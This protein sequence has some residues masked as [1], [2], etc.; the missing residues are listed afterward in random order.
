MRIQHRPSVSQI[1]PRNAQGLRHI[2][3][4]TSEKT[5]PDQ[6]DLAMVQPVVDMNMQ[7]Y[8]RLPDS[9][10]MLEGYISTEANDVAS[11][12]PRL[13]SYVSA[14]VPGSGE[15]VY[16]A[17]HNLLVFALDWFLWITNAD[18]ATTS[19]LW[20]WVS[21]EMYVPGHLNPV[22]I[23]RVKF[24]R[25]TNA[26]D[27]YYMS[28][29]SE[30][31]QGGPGTRSTPAFILPAGC[32]LEVRLQTGDVNFSPEPAHVHLTY[33]GLSVQVKGLQVPQGAPIPQL[34]FN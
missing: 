19:A 22:S 9:R 6:I 7:G 17:N 11:I 23:W 21:L 4:I 2:F 16:D 29:E 13:I 34:A 3:N 28:T 1:D 14:A 31:T 12:H 5:N 24:P 8:A 18:H 30:V 33:L 32:W 15:L 27:Y 10:N 25:H 26:R 20:H